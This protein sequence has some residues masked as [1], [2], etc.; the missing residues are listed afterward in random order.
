MLLLP[1][2]V[3][4]SLTGDQPSAVLVDSD[5]CCLPL[6]DVIPSERGGA[7]TQTCHVGSTHP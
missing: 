3:T 6:E 1:V 4:H 2:C 5:P 7:N